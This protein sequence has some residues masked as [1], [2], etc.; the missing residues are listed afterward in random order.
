[1]VKADVEILSKGIQ[2]DGIFSIESKSKEEL[3]KYYKSS[4]WSYNNNLE[5]SSIHH[6]NNQNDIEFQEKLKVTIRDYASLNQGEYLFRVNVFNRNSFVPKRY[7]NRK[8]PLKV[9]RGYKD[10]DEYTIQIP[11]GYKLEVVPNNIALD[12]K[13]GVYKV[14][15]Q[16]VDEKTLK[17]TKELL[18]KEGLYPKEDYKLY[19]KFRRSVAKYDNLRIAL[20]KI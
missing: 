17:Y 20:T 9:T 10:V 16:K 19:R 14:S 18:I 6:T 8:L 7:R 15:F 11:E 5:V 13:F 1:G 12:T 4:I 2:Y 3:K